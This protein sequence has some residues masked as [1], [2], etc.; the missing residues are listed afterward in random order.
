MPFCRSTYEKAVDEREGE[1]E[2]TQKQ[3]HQEMNIRYIIIHGPYAPQIK[4]ENGKSMEKM[5]FLNKCL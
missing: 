4:Q 2:T 3:L 1:I 5:E